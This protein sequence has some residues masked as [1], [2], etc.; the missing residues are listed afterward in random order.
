M[1]DSLAFR[2]SGNVRIKSNFLVGAQLIVE[3][4][5][6]ANL[7]RLTM[8]RVRNLETKM[9]KRARKKAQLKEGQ[10]QAIRMS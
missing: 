7:Q 3:I 8:V 5:L 4:T 10:I 6:G 9:I 1:H 2:Q